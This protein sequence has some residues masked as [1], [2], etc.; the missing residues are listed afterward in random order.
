MTAPR[1]TYRL[2]FRNG[3]DFAAAARLAP[4]LAR[5]GISHVYAS[6][7]FAART[8]STHGYDVIDFSRFDPSLGDLADFERMVE[9]LRRNDLGLIVDFVPNHMAASTENAWWLDVLTNGHSS[10]YATI[11]DI[12]W[13]RYGGRVLVPV[14]GDLYGRVLNAGEITLVHDKD[15]LR[16][17]YFDHDFP[18]APGS[19]DQ[20]AG[21]AAEAR[22]RAAVAREISSD[23][24]RLH[25]L[26]EA[27][28]YRLAHWRMAPDALNYRRFFEIN[29]LVGL[30][31][32]D[33]DVF[34]H[35]HRFVLELV[36]E[37]LVDGLR[38]DHIDGLADPAGYLKRLHDEWPAARPPCIFV[39]KI[40][41]RGE[42]LRDWPVLGT[43]GYEF[44]GLVGALQTDRDGFAELVAGYR[45]FTGDAR[46]FQ[47]VVDDAR[48]FILAL[49][50]SGELRA[51]AAGAEVIASSDLAWRD[52]AIEAIRR[53]L[54]EYLVAFPIYRSYVTADAA[55]DEDLA[56][57]HRACDTAARELG[58]EGEA[59]VDFLRT[60]LSGGIDGAAE[61]AVRAQQLTGPLMA[62]SVEDTAFYRYVPLIS[63]N[64]V[65]GE[66]VISDDAVDGFHQASAER[67]L[68]WPGC[69]LAA[70]TH[71]TKRGE[72]ARARL[73]VLSE[74]PRE[75][76][77]AVRRWW[78][79]LAPFRRPLGGHVAP[80]P[81]EG[82]HFFQALVAV[83]PLNLS[84]EDDGGLATLAGRLAGYMRK[85]LRE[86]K[87][88]TRWTDVDEEHEAAVLAWIECAFDPA[89][90]GGFLEDVVRTV[91]GLAPAAAVNS[92]A[93]AV[94]R[95]AAPGVPDIYQ[96]SE[97]LNLS[98]VDPDNRRPVDFAHLDQALRRFGD[99]G[100]DASLDHWR[101]GTLKLHVIANAL[102]LRRAS[103]MLFADGDY[104]AIEPAGP[105]AHR[106]VAFAR[107]HA[108][109]ALVA[110]VPRLVHGLLTGGAPILGDAMA[111]ARIPL[112]E[113][114][115]DGYAW[116]D[117]LSRRSVA[118]T[119][120]LRIGDLPTRLP[121]AL[122]HG[123][124]S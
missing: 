68:R 95:I 119:G 82:W 10:P 96:G 81:K 35:V 104:L 115:L 28:H 38:I 16:L 111:D 24:D 71:D 22:G 49:S 122:L 2:Q 43:T 77:D 87:E 120:S 48:R 1:A 109:Q 58:A 103:P 55:S 124:R 12:D 116:T 75:F 14:L 52:L 74:E 31:V 94:L 21:D 34:W 89:Q 4:Y 99:T 47:E 78:T 54:V 92:L 91:E 101:D 40:L 100:A 112:S 39:E 98:L 5:L 56:L 76:V 88:H 46:S 18:L 32:E 33:P 69:M 66:P 65:G 20:V 8:G 90:N 45:A 30:R 83:W 57:V 26:L 13:T 42:R 80:R 63:L 106:I 105:E 59:A 3:M 64:E 50:F 107:R 117:A 7:V 67:A 37:G 25:R 62:K 9:A 123:T 102:A 85:A 70:S 73:A 19:L 61:L 23:P 36:A 72:D 86:A 60:S 53:A 114:G 27:Q 29:D 6:P 113:H 121:V 84:V 118:P 11:F 15:E 51:L 93:E 17:R 110:C 41:G 79:M 108:D 97:H 44:A